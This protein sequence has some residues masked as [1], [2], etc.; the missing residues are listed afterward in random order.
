MK[1]AGYATLD[2][3][4]SLRLTEQLNVD[5]AAMNLLDKNYRTHGSGMDAPGRNLFV[6]LRLKF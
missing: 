3:R 5:V 4:G 2:L 1:T 6:R